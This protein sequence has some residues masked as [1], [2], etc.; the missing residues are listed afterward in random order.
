MFLALVRGVIR[1]VPVMRSGTIRRPPRSTMRRP[2][3]RM[4]GVLILFCTQNFC[5]SGN[6]FSLPRLG[7]RYRMRRSSS[8]TLGFQMRLRFVFG[9]RFPELSAS[10]LPCPFL[11]A[12]CHRCRVRFE[13]PYASPTASKPYFFQNSSMAVLFFAVSVII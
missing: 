3:V 4:Q 6:N 13:I 12:R 7:R 11:S 10:S 1:P 9:V 8:S 2:M 5:M